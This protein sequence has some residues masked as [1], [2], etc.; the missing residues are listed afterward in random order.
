MEN[1][2]NTSDPL[3][4]CETSTKPIFPYSL[5]KITCENYVKE[6]PWAKTSEADG[7]PYLINKSCNEKLRYFFVYV[8]L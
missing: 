3:C 6:T 8:S 5:V 7:L 2:I 4:L 1:W